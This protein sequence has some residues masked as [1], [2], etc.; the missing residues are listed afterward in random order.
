MADK[1]A[2]CRNLG[3]HLPAP[4]PAQRS[5]LFPCFPCSIS[6]VSSF[7]TQV[8]SL[9]SLFL[10]T[11]T[12]LSW[13]A[14]EGPGIS[15]DPGWPMTRAGTASPMPAGLLR[16]VHQLCLQRLHDMSQG[17]WYSGTVTLTSPA[18]AF[19][20]PAPQRLAQGQAC[21]S[22]PPVPR[23]SQRPNGHTVSGCRMPTTGT[24][25]ARQG[26]RGGGTAN[27]TRPSRWV[28]IPHHA[29]PN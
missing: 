3:L 12:Q 16:L 7:T 25:A 20:M 21:G 15:S 24:L 17:N 22:N 4:V 26:R 19:S 10:F 2:D 27:H 11:T 28:V 29:T 13:L 18:A 6:C 8:H 1:A 5:V 9:Q 14:E 23:L